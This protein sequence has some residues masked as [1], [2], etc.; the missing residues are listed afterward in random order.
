MRA[1]HWFIIGVL[2]CF[3]GATVWYGV[4]VWRATSAMPAY[5][6]IAMAAGAVMSLVIGCGLIA[7]MFY[8]NRKG[9]DEPPRVD[10]ETRRK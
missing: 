6:H 8:S 3:L 4:E 7:L 9:H 1:G 5:A 10:D 2:L